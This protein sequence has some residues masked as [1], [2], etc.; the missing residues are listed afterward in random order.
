MGGKA[1]STFRPRSH[2][3]GA[4]LASLVVSAAATGFGVIDTWHQIL[5]T[6]TTTWSLLA[7]IVYSGCALAIV[8][9]YWPLQ[10]TCLRNLTT[11]RWRVLSLICS[12]IVLLVATAT[13]GIHVAGVIPMAVFLALSRRYA[14]W[15]LV[16][17]GLVEIFLVSAGPFQIFT[18]T[19]IIIAGLTIITVLMSFFM[20]ARFRNEALIAQEQ[21]TRANIDKERLRIS[22]EL[23]DV[24]GRTFVAVSLR[25]QAALNLIDQDVERAKNQIQESHQAILCGRQQL[26]QLIRTSMTPDLSDELSSAKVI[27]KGLGI[28]VHADTEPIHDAALSKAI[29]EVLREGI[30]NMLKHSQPTTCWIT[31]RIVDDRALI[32]L[33]NDGCPP[34]AASPDTGTGLNHLRERLSRRGT[35][36]HAGPCEKNCFRLEV[37]LPIDNPSDSE[38]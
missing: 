34:D 3:P 32:R 28:T 19:E 31:V 8:A 9:V 5:T 2:F 30:T 15:G 33:I 11:M 17:T 26:Q 27:A 18:Q 4:E 20:L 29:A 1:H 14:W 7:S 23:H 25:Q 10:T 22:R 6:P 21:L 35:T 36:V 13:P 37:Q 38:K 12:V 16:I 24:I